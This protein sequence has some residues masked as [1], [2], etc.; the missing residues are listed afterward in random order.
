MEHLHGACRKINYCRRLPPLIIDQ[1]KPDPFTSRRNSNVRSN[2]RAV[3]QFTDAPP[4]RE[5]YG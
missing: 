2:A 5:I 4:I 3:D 1:L